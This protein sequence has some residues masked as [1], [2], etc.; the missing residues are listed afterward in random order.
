MDLKGLDATALAALV[1]KREVS[2]LELVDAAIARIEAGN[3]ALNAVVYKMYDEARAA[4]AGPLPEGPF[5]GV[6]W[7]VKDVIAKLKG[8]P[9]TEGSRLALD[10]VSPHDSELI[11]RQKRAGFVI[12]G[13]TNVPE[14][15]ILPTT[16]PIAHG[17]TRNPC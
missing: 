14:L 12:V 17:P 1:A 10:N 11:A 8:T 9:L 13:K 7:L 15:G 16:E 3:G 4:A 6:P 5:R 2:P